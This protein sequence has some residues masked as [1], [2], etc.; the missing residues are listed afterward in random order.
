[1]GV[2]GK[3]FIPYI[4]GFG[5]SVPAVLAS[6]TLENKKDRLLTI[7]TVPFVSCSA[8]LPV[9]IILVAAF[10]PHH[11]AI[12]LLS[13]YLIGLI[14]AILTSLILSKVAFK[15]ENNPF[16]M[17]LPPYRIPTFRNAMIHTWDKAKE[18]FSRVV[19]IVL[20][21]S[22]IIWGLGYFPQH[23]GN[24]SH[25][26]QLEQSYL[27]TIGK[28]IEP[29]F[30]PLGL[31][32]RAGVSLVAGCAA[33]EVIASSMAVLYGEEEVASEE[34]LTEANSDGVIP[35]AEKLRALQNDDGTPVYTPLSAFSLMLFILLYFPCIST[36]A[37]IQKESNT[38]WMLFSMFY[39]TGLAWLL[40]FLVFQI[41][42][43]V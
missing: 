27:G 41:G 30:K 3:S 16:V 15:E 18:W 5:C 20:I 33:K 14:I 7:L 13:I 2:H 34:D 32:W 29:V 10:F 40:S 4:I 22:V 9:Y 12:V 43:L 37:T 17:E 11:Q 35:L 25:R 42:S 6:R 8:R 26:E 31:E 1:M 28:A 21:A 36:L 39:S 38:K 24:L 23:E 19:T